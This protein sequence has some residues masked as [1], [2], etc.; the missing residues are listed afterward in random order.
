MAL[1]ITLFLDHFRGYGTRSKKEF[2]AAFR[3]CF[4][5]IG[6]LR[7]LG[8]QKPLTP[9]VALTATANL[10]TQESILKSLCMRKEC[11]RIFLSPNRKNIYLYKRKVTADLEKSFQWLVDALKKE[12]NAMEKTIVYCKS[13]KDCGRLFMFFKLELGEESFFPETASTSSNLLFGM[14]HH[15]TLDKQQARV[16]NSFHDPDGVV[17]LVFAKPMPLVWGSTFPMSE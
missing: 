11:I 13:I 1:T 8:P 5:R 14:F 12:K 3:E 15:S 6:E 16:L 9:V 10:K 2:T 4:S 7:S 17:R